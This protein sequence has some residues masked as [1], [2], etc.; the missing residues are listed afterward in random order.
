MEI[1][2]KLLYDMANNM[3]EWC[4]DE[5]DAGGCNVA[6]RLHPS[7]PLR[8]Y[9]RKDAVAWA[10]R[11]GFSIVMTVYGHVVCAVQTN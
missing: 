3:W 11:A 7:H 10:E 8:W 2:A 5:I 6:I 4:T 1:K 9:G